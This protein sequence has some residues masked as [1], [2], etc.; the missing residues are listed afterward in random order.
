[1]KT[2]LLIK[3]FRQIALITFLSIG[4]FSFAQT[5]TPVG[6]PASSE[7]GSAP[8]LNFNYTSLVE[9]KVVANLFLFN[10]D[11]NGVITADWGGWKAGGSVANLPATS[12][13][14]QQAVSVSLPGN[15]VLSSNLPVGKIYVWAYQIENMAGG[16]LAGGQTSTTIIASN[17]ALD[18]IAINNPPTS[19]NAGSTITI[20]VNYTLA[21]ARLIKFGISK[22]SSAG[23]WIEDLVGTGVDN[24]PG[25]TTTAVTLTQDL[26]I[27]SNAVPSASLTNGEYY[28]IDA[29]IFTPGYAA[30]KIGTNTNITITAAPLGVD[31]FSKNSF[32]IFPNPVASKLYLNDDFKSVKVY[33]MSGKK[34]VEL[35]NSS[36]NSIDVS[37][38]GKGTYIL[39]SDNNR[40]TKF[41]KE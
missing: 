39:V 16:Y 20:S 13:N 27:P 26:V 28:K 14:V 41:I 25:T 36:E 5:I 12:T 19:I 6:L 1:M 24:L 9:C 10:I 30:Y 34:V 35:N 32:R 8:S 11:G 17:N 18:I 40:K 7:V 31:D 38:L 23:A 21:G 15:L 33:D 37:Q 3:S 22:F 4:L 2:V 29:A